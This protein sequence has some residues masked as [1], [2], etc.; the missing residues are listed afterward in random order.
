MQRANPSMYNASNGV[1]GR[2]FVNGCDHT[3]IRWQLL[4]YFK[5]VLLIRGIGAKA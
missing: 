2:I 3:Q 1:N 4:P 5:G